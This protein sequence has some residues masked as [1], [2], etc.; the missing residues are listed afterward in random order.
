LLLH[1]HRHSL[2]CQRLLYHNKNSFGYPLR[3][4]GRRAAGWLAVQCF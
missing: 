3:L 2:F 4:L 1:V